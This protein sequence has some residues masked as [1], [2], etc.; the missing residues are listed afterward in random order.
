MLNARLHKCYSEEMEKGE[1]WRCWKGLNDLEKIEKDDIDAIRTNL[2]GVLNENIECYIEIKRKLPRD[3]DKHYLG[4]NN[5][6][7]SLERIH[8]F[9]EV[10]LGSTISKEFTLKEREIKHD[11]ERSDWKIISNDKIREVFMLRFY[12]KLYTLAGRVQALAKKSS[13]VEEGEW[14]ER[15]IQVKE[16]LNES[17][18]KE[19]IREIEKIKKERFTKT[20][21]RKLPAS[22]MELINKY[23]NGPN[24][25]EY[26]LLGDMIEFKVKRILGKLIYGRRRRVANRGCII[27]ITGPDGAGKSTISQAIMELLGKHVECKRVSFTPSIGRIRVSSLKKVSESPRKQKK[28]RYVASGI[29]G[30]LGVAWMIWRSAK[31]NY[32]KRYC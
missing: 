13:I 3:R 15:N 20:M 9:E 32:C 11:E 4:W 17:K 12:T 27:A 2:E 31:T 16:N 26:Q 25:N 24:K 23:C 19:T 6:T 29:R 10:K 14:I 5:T 30:V 21:L 8:L 28:F 7:S 22:K 18:W 1:G